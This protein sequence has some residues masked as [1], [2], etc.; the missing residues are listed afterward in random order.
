MLLLWVVGGAVT[1]AARCRWR[2]RVGAARN[3]WFYAYLR[4]GWGRRPAFL[5]G[6]SELVLIRAN[7]LG[8]I[9]VV[10]GE[11]LLR[12]IGVDPIEHYIAARVPVRRRH[13][14]RRRA[15]TSVGANIGAFIVG[16]STW[17]KFSALLVLVGAAFLLGSSHGASALAPDDSGPA[18]RWRRQHG[19]G[20]R[21]RSLGV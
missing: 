20:T 16:I 10:F 1:C 2:A 21:Q 3:R 15:P 5:F 12:S 6:W 18:R 11:Y 7:A 8:G 13:R 4:E 19:T 14:L 9:A 17:A